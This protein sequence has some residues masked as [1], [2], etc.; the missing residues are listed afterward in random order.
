MSCES[1][2]VREFEFIKFME[3][4][5]RQLPCQPASTQ[6][7]LWLFALCLRKNNS[8]DCIRRRICV[9]H[10]IRSAPHGGR[11]RYWMLLRIYSHVNMW[12]CLMLNGGFPQ[13]FN[14]NFSR[15]MLN[16]YILAYYILSSV[17]RPFCFTH[18]CLVSIQ[19]WVE[20]LQNNGYRGIF[21]VDC[22]FWWFAERKKQA[23]KR[24]HH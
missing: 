17:A 3:T 5:L 4:T 10:L 7:V 20:I 24:E 23:P 1:V 13:K 2:S 12:T 19:R 18:E 21:H 8:S 11:S 9:W 16:I 22:F 6:G 14:A 15:K